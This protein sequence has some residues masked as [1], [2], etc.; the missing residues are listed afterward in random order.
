MEVFFYNA[1]E[2]LLKS[3]IPDAEYQVV[4]ERTLT[5]ITIDYQTANGTDMRITCRAT[6][7]RISRSF[8]MVFARDVPNSNPRL[9]ESLSHVLYKVVQISSTL[10]MRTIDR[11]KPQPT[12]RRPVDIN[13]NRTANSWHCVRAPGALGYRPCLDSVLG[14]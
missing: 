5:L 1:A 2:S 9:S 3:S 7:G 12:H 8:H 11:D 13:H 10:S 14:F 6:D 4:G